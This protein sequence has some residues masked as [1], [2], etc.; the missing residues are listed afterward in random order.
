MFGPLARVAHAAWIPPLCSATMIFMAR[1]QSNAELRHKGDPVAVLILILLAALP[2]VN[3]LANTFVYDDG[4]QILNNPYVHSF[5]YLG[6]I[7][8]STVWTFEGAQGTTNYYRPLMSFAYLIAYK[9]FGPIPFGFHLMNLVF[10][11]AIVLLLFAVTERLFGNRLLSFIAAGLFALHPIHTESVAWVAAITDLELSAFFLLTFFLYLRIG[12]REGESQ[13]SWVLYLGIIAAYILALLSKEQALVLPALLIVYE[14]FYRRNAAGTRFAEK[15]QRY[16]PVCLVAIAYVAFR[17]FALGGFAPAI[18]RPNMSWTTVLLSALALTGSYLRKLIWPTHLTA[19]YVFHESDSFRDPR[20]LAGIFGLVVCAGIFVWLWR[21]D[22]AVSFAFLWMGAT[23]APVLNPRWMPAQVFAERYLYLPSIGFCWLLGWAAAKLWNFAQAEPQSTSRLLLRQALT[24]GLIA[25]ASFYAV[26]TVRR[27]PDWRTDEILYR[28]TLE[29]QPDAQIIRTNLGVVYSD[30]N[31]WADAEREWTLALGPAPANAATLNDIGLVRKN[32]KRYGE[33]A[34][35]FAR[36]LRLRPKFVDPY[37]NLAEMYAGMGRTADADAN[38]RQ[39]VALAPLNVKV[40]NSYGHFLLQQGRNSEA[41]EQFA[42]SA[43]ADANA[44]A[45]DNLGD[46]DLASGDSEKARADFQA[47]LGLNRYDNHA[48][49][50]VA[51]IDERQGRIADAVREYRAGLETDPRNAIAL[52][53]V[54]RL[55]TRA[56]Q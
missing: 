54:E 50:G 4:P 49:F 13:R 31:D 21:R 40:R 2:Y 52:A 28:R 37:K 17:R 18:W 11:V 27:N 16:L 25:I 46:L 22:R 42:R 45:Y 47:V 5:H 55:T 51:S 9:V 44:E 7:F 36:A 26:V 23:L 33:A 41:R 48:Y 3:S 15:F 8:G 53:A 56:S 6:K 24:V 32:Q 38:F 12:E 19:F 29:A 35:C 1:S 14:H 43:E 30:R 20:V 10:H 34:D 39:A